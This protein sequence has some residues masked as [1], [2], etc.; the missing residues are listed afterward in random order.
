L[1]A[2][3]EQDQSPGLRLQRLVRNGPA[4]TS[5]RIA[6]DS[7]FHPLLENGIK[8][9]DLGFGPPGC[10]IVAVAKEF[11]EL[12]A[13]AVQRSR[14]VRIEF[15]PIRN[16][17]PEKAD[18]LGRDGSH[19]VIR[20]EPADIAV[21]VHGAFLQG[22]GFGTKQDL[23]DCSVHILPR[24]SVNAD[25]NTVSDFEAAHHDLLYLSVGPTVRFSSVR[26]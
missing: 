4:V 23:D 26:R 3:G 12:I 5:K 7:P 18:P 8:L 9:I 10:E 11:D 25:A 15:P 22:F 16:F 2:A 13:V 20:Q 6:A 19:Q 17:V 21:E 14:F 24:R 1:F